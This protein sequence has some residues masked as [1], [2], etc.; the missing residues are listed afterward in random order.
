MGPCHHLLFYSLWSNK[1]Q[2]CDTLV[3]ESNVKRRIVKCMSFVKN[4]YHGNSSL[5]S[6]VIPRIIK[7][8]IIIEVRYYSSF[9][10]C[11]SCCMAYPRD[12]I[13]SKIRVNRFSSTTF[14]L[15]PVQSTGKY[16]DFD[17]LSNFTQHMTSLAQYTIMWQSLSN[18]SGNCT[19]SAG[20]EKKL[21]ISF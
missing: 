18:V 17:T 4:L 7:A 8:I 13:S 11:I 3:Y 12:L 6:Y 14:I 16:I 19:T 15:I 1:R 10:A 9:Y 2:F 5:D 21:A 20:L